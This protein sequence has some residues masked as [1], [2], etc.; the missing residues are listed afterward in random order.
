[1]EDGDDG[2]DGIHTPKSKGIPSVELAVFAQMKLQSSL[3]GVSCWM[4]KMRWWKLGLFGASMDYA[5]A[6]LRFGLLCSPAYF[7]F[8][9]ENQAGTSTVLLMVQDKFLKPVASIRVANQRST[10][11][12]LEV[13]LCAVRGRSMLPRARCEPLGN[14]LTV[15][16][17]LSGKKMSAIRCRGNIIQETRG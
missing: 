15:G 12:R 10:A 17:V 6:F 8:V 2:D 4:R 14:R 7:G 11:L 1:M 9:G 13:L 16:R 3:E 5:C